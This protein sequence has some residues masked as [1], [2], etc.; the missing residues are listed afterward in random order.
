ME[1]FS[2]LPC[3]SGTHVRP[4]F[5]RVISH[6]HKTSRTLYVPSTKQRFRELAD[7]LPAHRDICFIV[8]QHLALKSLNI[9]DRLGKRL[10]RLLRQVVS[11]TTVDR[12]MRISAREFPSIGI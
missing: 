3:S 12:S 2:F 8:L 9:H 7:E 5:L 4:C 6:Y 10:R 11:H 1:I